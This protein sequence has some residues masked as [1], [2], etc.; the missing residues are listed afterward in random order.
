MAPI[1]LEDHVA[2]LL[3]LDIRHSLWPS[4]SP[5]KIR[6]NRNAQRASKA[7]F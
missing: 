4:C 7:V 1:V 3:K 5:H 2:G 6:L